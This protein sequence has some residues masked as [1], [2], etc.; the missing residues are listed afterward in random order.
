MIEMLK[1]RKEQLQERGVKGFTLMEML[2]VIAIIAILIAIAIPIFTSQLEAARDATSVANLRSAYAEAN[3]QYL[4]SE[5]KAADQK[6]VI[7]GVVIESS[8]AD[9][10]DAGSNLPFSVTGITGA[11]TYTVT[12]TLNPT[13]GTWSASA[14]QG[15]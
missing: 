7:S 9:L 12:F 2:I 6:Q 5:M 11:G 10:G 4:T 14:A 13:A 3:A 1:A 15:S 8:D